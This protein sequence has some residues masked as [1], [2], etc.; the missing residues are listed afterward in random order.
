M[1]LMP[2]CN[3]PVLS[4]RNLTKALL[5]M[6]FTAFLMIVSALQLSAK[7]FGQFI[8]LNL[9]N[10]PIQRAFKEIEKQSGYSFVYGKE[11]LVQT[12]KVTLVVIN[13]SL[14]DALSKLFKGQPL[15]YTISGRYIAI[16]ISNANLTGSNQD[17]GSKQPPVEVRGRLKSENGEP[18]E[19]ISVTVKG[20]NIGTQTNADGIFTIEVPN[21]NSVL[22][23]TGVGYE[24]KELKVG[25]KSD[26]GDI[27]L[28][29]SN[30]KLN[31]IVVVGYSAQRRKDITGAVSVV[32]TEDLKTIPSA[33]ATSQLQGRASGV[34]VLLNGIPGAP[35]K[36]R[37]R[38]LGSFQNNNPLYVVDGVQTDDISGLAPNDIESMQVLKDAASASIYGVRS[39]NGVIVITTKKGRKG[40]SVSF[41]MTYGVQLPGEGYQKTVVLSPQEAAEFTFMV[42]RNSGLPTTGTIYGD[43]PTP[44]LP[45]YT[46]AGL[47][48]TSGA[49][50]PLY[51]GNPA[52]D[53]SLYSLDRSR[54]GDPGPP[55]YQPYIIVR[56]NK[57]GTNW[58]KEATRNAPIQNYNVTLSSGN[59]NSRFLL[60]LNYFDQQAIT[61]YQFYKRY[62]A[63]LNCEF[64]VLK[65]IRIG[66]NVQL[67]A[68]ESN[69]TGNNPNDYASNN[70]PGADFNSLL[71]AN[72][73]VPV[74]T[75]KNG[76]W[77]G[78]AGV[79]FATNPVALFNRKKDNR[80]NA[81]NI[82]GNLYG[83]VDL[84]NHLTFRSSFGGYI[85]TKNQYSYPFIEY[86]SGFNQNVPTYSENF[87][88]SNNW[89]FTNQLSYKN[90]FGKHSIFAL[91]GSEATK[92]GGRQLL[93]SASG[94]YTYAYTPFI[95][96]SNG[97]TQNLGGSSSFTPATT[98]SLF[99]SVNYAFDNKYLLSALVR[100]DGSSKF[101]DPFK[102]GTFPAFS[103]G[104][105][106]S[107]EKF[108]QNIT[109]IND[110]KLRGSWGTSGNEAAL[111]AAN[112]YTTFVSARGSSFYDNA[113]TQNN[114]QGGFYG[115]FV[116][117]VKG[118]WEENVSSNM[119]FDATILNNSTDIVFDYYNKETKGL[120]YNPTVQAILGAAAASNPAFRNVGSMKNWG[121][122]LLINNRVAISKSIKLNTTLTFTTYK[123]K[124]TGINDDGTT[125]FI[126]GSPSRDAD[127]GGPITR[128]M[129]GQPLNVYFGYKVIGIFQSQAEVDAS[130]SQTGGGVSN[131]AYPGS[132]KYQDIS[133]PNGKPDGV[134]D[135]YDRTVI[136]N[137]NPKFTYGL[138]FDLEYKSF[139]LSA[140]FYGVDG[141]QNYMYR[142]W[143]QDFSNNF[144]G[145]S[146]DGLY[147][148]WL[149]D[150]SRPN[151][152]VPMQVTS[153]SFSTSDVVSS[154]FVENASYFRL[155]NLQ[156]GYTF[157]SK[158]LSKVRISK[159]RVYIQA[160]NLFTITK[161]T[162]LD[163]EVITNDERASGIDLGSYPTVKQISFGTNINF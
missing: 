87:I 14:E 86:E 16:K 153:G 61:I 130:P 115:N 131:T 109:W 26:L 162:G 39:S 97:A 71:G 12:K 55:P 36:V 33:N 83:E 63:R 108:M 58:W 50:G 22:V 59:D 129:I 158:L 72:P 110:L 140:F 148:S 100:R 119:G 34:T 15:T 151:A 5:I 122:D 160:T 134:I 29:I 30:L 150:G 91:I 105:R 123:N 143:F 95:N 77:A 52:V 32:N 60:S 75:I 136:G 117:N 118:R 24:K 154:Y 25:G 128:N 127:R 124:V 28:S 73:I 37:V 13:S 45:D 64:N 120:L 85:N 104:W 121:I 10:V 65:K 74:Y 38:G 157:N 133:G 159:A 40:V 9:D 116:G 113:G 163:P 27:R 88:R 111:G 152:K 155:R 41:D 6:K 103:L 4:R 161:Y 146:K 149:P 112:A 70:A 7:G 84:T 21:D 66:E 19:G 3:P 126:Y 94:Y 43:G 1:D 139:Y 35:A 31:E 78:S 53:P 69:V 99:A 11:Q 2:L 67:Y 114:P 144:G 93:N 137:P 56:A 135:S 147:N 8:T 102:Y 20:T 145:M 89:I 138:N 90:D 96:L 76:D 79:G 51:E 82:F 68:S 57:S 54:I 107:N 80:D 46:F 42:L 106:I 92:S 132:F 156:I 47:T 101:I 48:G 141:K 49:P 142:R 98:A 44:I 17:P 125:F 62:N 23:F 81:T 18:L